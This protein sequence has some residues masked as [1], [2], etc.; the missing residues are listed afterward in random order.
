VNGRGESQPSEAVTFTTK[1]A[2]YKYDFQLAGNPL[3]DGYTEITPDTQYTEET[4]IG[5]L[6]ALPA[7]AGRDRGDQGG[8]ADDLAR[9]FVLP[10]DSSTFALDVPNGTYS[11]KT[12][13]GDFIGSSKTSFRIEGKDAGSG[14]A[15]KGGVNET[16][17]GPFLVTDGRIDIEAYGAAA[18][19]RLNGLEITPILLGPTGLEVSDVDADPE[20]PAIS[21]SWDDVAG[22]TWNVYRTS[23]FDSAAVLV[24][25][26]DAPSYTDTDA[27]VGLEY[28]YYV[29]AVD[30][31]GLE[32]VPSRAVPVSLIDDGVTP[33][34]AASDVTVTATEKNLVSFSWRPADDAA[35]HLVFR[36]EKAG[37]RG[38]LIGIADGDDYADEDVLTTIPYYYTVVG[39]NAGGAGDDSDQIATEAVTTLERQTEYLDRTPRTA[40]SSRGACSVRTPTTSR[41]TCTA[42]A[43]RSRANRSRA[44]RICSTR[45]DPTDPST[46]SRRCSTDAST[47]RP[48]T[49]ACRPAITCRC[50]STSRPTAIRRT[51]SPSRTRRTTRASVTSTATARTSCSSSG[52]RRTPRTTRMR[53]TRAT[54]C[55]MPTGSTAPVCGASISAAT[56]GPARTTRSSRCSTTTAT[57]GPRW[58]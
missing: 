49:S 53:A 20:S 25:E 26:V 4:G 14:N 3:M 33:P 54:F 35:F 21:L 6:E 22:V 23:L 5:F 36:S 30:Q 9:D 27:R 8:S 38:E 1:E 52:I 16:L 45:A 39:V 34:A 50:R 24:D 31:T 47:P 17:R 40:C 48:R 12:Y 55:S 51:A 41:S 19:S 42:T 44:R 32:S 57:A 18:G 7:D 10:G 56:S 15:G 13:S 37:E 58:S 28:E 2:L 43:R 29:T 11:V 46:P